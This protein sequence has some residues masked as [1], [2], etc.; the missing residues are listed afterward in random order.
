MVTQK[1]ILQNIAD[2]LGLSV[3]DIDRDATFR[4][5][6]GLGPVE[7]NDLIAQLSQRLEVILDPE[8]VSGAKTVEDVII[9]IED[10][11]I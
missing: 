7:F 5:D 3:Q 4:D 1:E 6:L 11:L 9:L 10:N 2:I 8:E